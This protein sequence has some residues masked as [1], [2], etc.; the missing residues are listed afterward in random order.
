MPASIHRGRQIR[1]SSA[2]AS[3]MAV[4]ALSLAGCLP[5]Q[6]RSDGSAAPSSAATGSAQSMP[7]A[8]PSGPPVRPSFVAPTPTPAPTFAVYTVVRGDSLTTIA[9]RFGTTAR[10]IAFWNRSTYPSLDPDSAA[11][12]PNLLQPGWT[13]VVVP[14]VILDEQSLPDP[15]V[16]PTGSPEAGPSGAPPPS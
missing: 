6:T 11:Y 7:V 10:S 12:H 13:L 9:Y 16:A 15:S 3:V 4:T 14:N 2:I 8:G 5:A 1:R